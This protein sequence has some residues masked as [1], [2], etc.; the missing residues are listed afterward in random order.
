MNKQRS[1]I[2]FCFYRGLNNTKK[3]FETIKLVKPKTL[4]LASDGPLL[5][6]Y[7]REILNIRKWVLDSINWDCDVKTLFR[8]KNL[9]VKYAISNAIN[10]V[11]SL[12]DYFFVI[13][14]DCLVHPLFIKLALKISNQLELKGIK[15][16]N[17]C[18]YN[19]VQEN[20]KKLSFKR[21]TLVM[22]WGWYVKSSTWKNFNI[23]K[24]P[25]FLSFLFIFYALKNK[26][27]FKSTI[28]WLAKIFDCHVNNDK[29]WGN[30]YAIY[31]MVNFIPSFIPSICLCNNIGI[32]EEIAT[33]STYLYSIFSNP[34]FN[35]NKKIDYDETL[36]LKDFKNIKNDKFFGQQLFLIYS[37]KKLIFI[38]AFLVLILGSKSK[39]LY[40]IFKPFYKFIKRSL[41]K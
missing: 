37:Q 38:K 13:E 18:S 2:L 32:G 35:L 34:S 26:I 12:E 1:P 8:D 22:I 24:L 41:K 6:K 9:G 15:E 10:W 4:Y 7:N 31:C 30:R 5:D 21:A 29:T 11:A 17:I 36:L 39:I 28:F 14:S 20:D 23:N 3:S 16:Y 19:I 27:G 33:N 25:N 40:N